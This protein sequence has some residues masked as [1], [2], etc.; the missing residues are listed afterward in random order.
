MVLIEWAKGL[1][2]RYFGNSILSLFPSVGS[3]LENPDLSICEYIVQVMD[4]IR[5][6]H[7]VRKISIVAH[8]LGGLVARYAIGRLYRLSAKTSSASTPGYCPNVEGNIFTPHVNQFYEAR[9]GGLEP[10]NFVT[11]A[12]PHLGSRGHKQ[13]SI[14]LLHQNLF[15]GCCILGA[16]WVSM[17]I[18]ISHWI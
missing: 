9:I 2:K 11:F 15:V 4:V 12:T 10:I 16:F 1:L 8:S 3:Y 17:V 6:W 13:V 7:G 14:I 5:R 18:D